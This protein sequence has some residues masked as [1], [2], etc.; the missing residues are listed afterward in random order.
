MILNMR[1]V[2]LADV[3]ELSGDLEAK[4][5]LRDYLKEFSK[6]GKKQAD[7]LANSVRAIDSV[8]MRE[9]FIIKIVDLLPRDSESI[10]KIFNDVSLDEKETNEILAVVKEY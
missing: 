3:Q 9:E 4:P 2:H 5:D 6:L 10:S 1:P 7:A 8:K